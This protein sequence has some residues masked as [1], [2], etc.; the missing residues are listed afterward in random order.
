MQIVSLLHPEH[1]QPTA[2]ASASVN[3]EVLV[4]GHEISA[5]LPKAVVGP[6]IGVLMAMCEVVVGEA[7]EH[8]D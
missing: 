2:P 3:P 4:L 8:P 6:K 7:V 5:A 1:S